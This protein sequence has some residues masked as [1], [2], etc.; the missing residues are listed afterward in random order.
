[1]ETTL[2]A[3]PDVRSAVTG[4]DG[5]R[6]HENNRGRR[7]R[8]LG[9]FSDVRLSKRGDPT[10]PSLFNWVSQKIVR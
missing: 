2:F 1:M 3:G 5:R 4:V 7:R 9:K 6:E 8:R 10:S